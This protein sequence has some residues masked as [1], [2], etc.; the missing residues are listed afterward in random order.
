[1]NAARLTLLGSQHDEL[2]NYLEAHPEGNERAAIVLFRRLHISVDGLPDSD[3]Y[4]AQDVIPF[5]EA[6]INSSSPTHFD[7]KLAPL[8]EI[9]RR[10]EEEKLVFG[11]IHNHPEG[12]DEFS[13]K[14]DENEITLLRAISN[15]NGKDITFVAMLWANNVWKARVRAAA[16]PE[17][18]VP[19]RHTLVTTDPLKIYG[20]KE[21]SEDH[22]ETHKRGAAAF[23]QP[24]VD[25]LQSLRVGVVGT[26]GTGSPFAT[27]G[28]RAGISELVLIDDDDLALSNLN[29]VR[30]LKRGDV[31]DKKARKLKDFIDDIGVSVKVGV[32]ESKIDSDPNALDALASCD[33]VVGCTDDFIGR[34]VMNIALYAYAQLYIDLGL[35]GRVMDDKTGQPGLRY[36]F[37]RIS[38]ILPES[39]ECLFCQ[40]VIH[41]KWIQTQLL[42]RENPNITKEELKERYLEDGGEEAPGVGP[43]TSATADFALATLFDLIKPYRRY[44]PVLRKDMIQV[45]F[46]NM[47]FRSRQTK[48][49]NECPYC[50]HRKF[51]L[52]KET[53]RLKRPVLGKRD[54]YV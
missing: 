30:G 7:F 47:E 13:I 38:T 27:L 17:N 24:F 25:M 44:P 29:R 14:D 28:A 45:D 11:F 8:R 10:C 43:F 33:V 9:F 54:E 41:E 37:G 19:V 4:I 53:Y 34:D 12:P 52:M 48:S 50:R 49:D 46:V 6:W 1:M 42:K 23:G 32:C 39:G 15:R 51:L 36:H 20:Y 40:G 2:V 3:R 21:S 16:M 5:D 26:G 22:S 18:T 31:G 35:G